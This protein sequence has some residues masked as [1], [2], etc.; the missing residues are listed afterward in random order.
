M[1][2]LLAVA[3]GRWTAGEGHPGG[4]EGGPGQKVFLLQ[5]QE[6]FLLEYTEAIGGMSG[7]QKVLF[8]R[9]QTDLL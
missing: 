7:R 4:A 5:H 6:L 1:P 3:E 8:A 9:L 2:R